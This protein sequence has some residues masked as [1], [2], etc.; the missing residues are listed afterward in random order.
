MIKSL[1]PSFFQTNPSSVFPFVS[2][3]MSVLSIFLL[4]D[5]ISS[6][7]KPQSV[8][9]SVIPYFNAV[10]VA[11]LLI[12]I[13]TLALLMS[14]F[15]RTPLCS[16]PPTLPVLMKY[17]YPFS[18]P[19]RIL[20][21]YLLRLLQLDHC[22]FILVGRVLTQGLRLTH[23]LWCPPPQRRYCR[24]RLIFPFP[25]EKVLI[26]PVLPPATPPRPLQVYTHRPRIDTKPPANSSPMAT[27]STTSVLPSP[28]DLP[29]TIRKGTR[30]SRNPHPIYNLLTYH[31]LSSPYSAFI[32]TLSFFSLPKTVHE[33]LSHLG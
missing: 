30:S 8:S 29:I 28:T 5:K 25:F 12:H 10:I 21:L 17:H 14:L 26:P 3:V 18:V 19:S 23:L 16:L 31:R 27:S 33:T 15:L 11:T 20:P 1:I 24:L 13:D 22:R 7:P 2:L 6:Q 32:S 4:I 9:S